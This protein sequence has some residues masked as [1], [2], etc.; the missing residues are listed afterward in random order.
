MILKWIL[1]KFTSKF[2]RNN[3]RRLLLANIHHHKILQLNKNSLKQTRTEQFSGMDTVL[4]YSSMF[5]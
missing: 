4:R 3:F 2:K 5:L 1:E